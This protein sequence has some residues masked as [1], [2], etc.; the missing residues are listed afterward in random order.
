MSD[1]QIR[2][3]L[4]AIAMP[5][6]EGL[7]KHQALPPDKKNANHAGLGGFCWRDW[8]CHVRSRD[9]KL[10]RRVETRPG[11]RGC[12]GLLLLVVGARG[13]R[14]TRDPLAALFALVPIG[15]FFAVMNYAPDLLGL[16]LRTILR[17]R[18]GREPVR[19]WMAIRGPGSGNAQNLVRQEIAENVVDW[20]GVKR[21]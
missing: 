13:A 7:A 12:F 17:R 1:P 9:I 3:P 6:A 18:R 2:G 16:P 5:I 14:G 15:G 20:R 4:S 19:F 11:W 10:S 8:L 21:R